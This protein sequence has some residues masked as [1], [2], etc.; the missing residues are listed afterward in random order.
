MNPGRVLCAA[1]CRRFVSTRHSPLA[2]LAGAGGSVAAF[3]RMFGTRRTSRCFAPLAGL[4]TPGGARAHGHT[5]RRR[6]ERPCSRGI[7]CLVALPEPAS[8][9]VRSESGAPRLRRLPQ[10][11]SSALASRQRRLWGH[12]PAPA[13]ARARP[14]ADR[15]VPIPRRSLRKGSQTSSQT[16]SAMYFAPANRRRRTG[17]CWIAIRITA[18]PTLGD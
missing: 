15:S 2:T 3:R 14:T 10:L 18:S 13:Q 8:L 9:A 5:L 16:A 4:P 17:R 11:Q 6:A 12:R 1:V 7:A